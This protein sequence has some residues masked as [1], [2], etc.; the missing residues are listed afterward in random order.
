MSVSGTAHYPRKWWRWGWRGGG[1]GGPPRNQKVW[2]GRGASVEQDGGVE[3]ASSW[4]DCSKLIDLVKKIHGRATNVL[5]EDSTESTYV[6][7]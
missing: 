7:V 3:E 4:T 5:I 6:L 2:G 1:G